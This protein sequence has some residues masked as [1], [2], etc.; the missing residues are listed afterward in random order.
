MKKKLILTLAS[1]VFVAAFAIAE[2]TYSAPLKGLELEMGNLL[3]WETSYEENTNLFIIEKSTDWMSFKN[4]GTVEASG[5]TDEE[6]SYRYMDTGLGMDKSYYRLKVVEEDGTSS[7]S[8]VATVNKTKPNQFSVVA[9]SSTLAEKTFDITIDALLPGQLEY[10]L[11]SYQGELVFTE[12]QILYPGLNELQVS[13]E[14]ATE[15]IYKIKLRV[16]NEEE[17]L[18]IQKASDEL[19][20]KVNMASTKKINRH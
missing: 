15:G 9:Y 3:S 10:E 11:V 18:V 12:F 1:I 2:V 14:D 7:Y 16:D 17:V 4:V 20:K 6:N 5:D 8:Q 19:A 13:M